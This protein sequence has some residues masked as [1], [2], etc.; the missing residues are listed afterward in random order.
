[1][2]LGALAMFY[3]YRW[4]QDLSRYQY[5]RARWD[6]ETGRPGLWWLLSRIGPYS[7]AI[8]AILLEDSLCLPHGLG[9]DPL[10][11]LP[12]YRGASQ[13]KR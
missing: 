10:L 3:P 12:R 5:A 1:M 9:V 4:K 13:P 6:R 8:R 7:E 11:G 2:F